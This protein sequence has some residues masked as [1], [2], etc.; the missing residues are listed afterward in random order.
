M[1]SLCRCVT[2]HAPSVAVHVRHTVVPLEWG[3][4]DG[5]VEMLC[6]TADTNVHALLNLYVEHSG[7]PPG[8]ELRRFSAFVR[9]LAEQAW[10][11][12]PKDPQGTALCDRMG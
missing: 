3:G 8:N 2:N 6:P 12:R 9:G 5:P 11:H 4:K 1:N 10:R 7:R